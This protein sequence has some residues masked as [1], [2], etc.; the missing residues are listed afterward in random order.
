MKV[1]VTG[2]T[3]L[4]GRAL[5]AFLLSD[6]REVIA[7]SRNEKAARALLDPD[8]SRRL[9]S[10]AAWDARSPAGLTPALAG[11]DA[12]VN[13]L[14]ENLTGGRWTAAKKRLLLESRLEAIA[15][16]VEALRTM[17]PSARPAVFVQ[18]SAV[19]YYGR[20][21]DEPLAESA[22]SGAGL[23]A[24][25]ARQCEQRASQIASLGVRLVAARSGVV[26]AREG[27]ALPRLALPSRLGVGGYPGSGA[28][29][30]SWIHLAD[31][32]SALSFLLDRADL[33]GPFNLTAPGAVTMKELTR[34]IGLTLHRP[35]L[36][37]I[38][39]FVMRLAFGEMA[40]EA[41]LSGQ[42]VGPER[43]LAAGFSFRYPEVSAALRNLL[44]PTREG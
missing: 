22:E 29:G 23:L 9:L 25:I 8:G 30:V 26:L 13:L 32:I 43:L 31:E 12:V 4:I 41:L 3:G 10:I 42:R 21:G 19:G 35:L 18:A 14:G 6:G 24:E 7:L 16:F 11:S 36:V 20:R 40:D 39:S 15:A 38:P 44:R 27:G 5:V 17:K 34:A 1:V 33:A 2:A 28:Q 37:P